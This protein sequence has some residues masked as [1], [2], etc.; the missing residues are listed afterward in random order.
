M[1][2]SENQ[3]T[4][5]ELLN[6]K[7]QFDGQRI[8][9]NVEVVGDLMKR[10]DVYVVNGLDETGAI[11]IWLNGADAKKITKLGS[12]QS[13]GDM[14]RVEG[15]YHYNCNEHGGDTDIH[16]ELVTLKEPG[17]DVVR[18]VDKNKKVAFLS[19]TLMLLMMGSYYY[20]GILKREQ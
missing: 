17:F 1:G 20:F 8:T 13:T 12:Y 16:A 6:N 2:F 14:I 15:V 9:L 19:T 5:A 11:G 10:G 4:V 18:K 3:V 7:E